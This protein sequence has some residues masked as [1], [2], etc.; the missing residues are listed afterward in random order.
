MWRIKRGSVAFSSA[1]KQ[2]S[3]R[4]LHISACDAPPNIMCVCP[5]GHCWGRRGCT[6]SC[7]WKGMS[8]LPGVTDLS[9]Q[10]WS[11]ESA[12]LFLMSPESQEAGDS[13]SSVWNALTKGFYEVRNVCASYLPGWILQLKV[14]H[15]DTSTHRQLNISQGLR[16][17]GFQTLPHLLVA[18]MHN[19]QGGQ[20]TLSFRNQVLPVQVS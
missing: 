4:S 16:P 9:S 2:V 12:F 14:W 7:F 11:I 5:H 15:A 1:N 18:E 10:Q 20:E 3:H 17:R 8:H 6:Q 13:K 19:E